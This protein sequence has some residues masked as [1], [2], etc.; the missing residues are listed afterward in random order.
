MTQT[1]A[2]STDTTLSY[3]VGGTA[4]SGSD[5]TALPLSVT[6]PAGATTA[7]IT[8]PINNDS[9][10]EPNETVIVTLSSITSGDSDISIGTHQ[11]APR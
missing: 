9:L 3:S 2:S 11:I 7:T 8:V 1:A 5:Y 4:T 6:I 10:V